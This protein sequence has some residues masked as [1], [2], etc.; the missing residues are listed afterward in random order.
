MPRIAR[1]SP[2][3]GILLILA[4]GNN[5]QWVFYSGQDFRYEN[6][7]VPFSFTKQKIYPI[8]ISIVC[9]VS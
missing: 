6:R 8:S 3:K 2:E 9:R 7:T 1:I 5:Y 4:R